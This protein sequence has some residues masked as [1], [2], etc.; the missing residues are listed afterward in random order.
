MERHWIRVAA[1]AVIV[2][3]TSAPQATAQLAP[4]RLAQQQSAVSAP[5]TAAAPQA[6]G[7][8]A[9]QPMYTPYRPQVHQQ[10]AAMTTG[11]PI[12]R[13][14]AAPTY[15][16]V[17]NNYAQVQP[18]YPTLTYPQ[19]AANY[20]TTPDYPQTTATY[21]QATPTYPETTSTYP[22]TTPYPESPQAYTPAGTQ[23]AQSPTPYRPGAMPYA[24]YATY[25]NT[26]Q[27]EELPANGEDD[28]LPPPSRNVEPMNG[29]SANGN[30]A[31]GYDANG[32]GA[33][34]YGVD[35]VNGA[36]ANGD[37]SNGAANGAA[38][39]HSMPNSNG[40]TT[41][42]EN[43]HCGHPATSYP[44]GYGDVGANCDQH[45]DWGL[46][47]YFDNPHHDSHWFGGVY[48]LLMTRDDSDHRRL[49]VMFDAPAGGYPGAEWTA[50]SSSHVDHDYR[51]GVEIRFGST[52][53]GGGHHD[54][55]DSACGT[56][57]GY[58]YG[59]DNSHHSCD[60]HEYAWEFGAW[61]LDDDVNTAQVVDSIP[62]DTDR[63]YGM[64]NFAGLSYNGRDVNEWYDYQMPVDPVN[65]TDV[66]ILAQ[67][68][69][70]SF[71]AQNVELNF[72][73]LPLCGMDSCG[74]GYAGDDCHGYGA[75]DCAPHYGSSFSMATLCG[76][77]YLRFD[78]DFEYG[79]MWATGAPGVL[80]PPAY[81]PWDGEGELV[82]D[83][84]VDNELYGFQLGANMNYS[85]SCR[86][87][88]FW[89][90]SFGMYN[91]HIEV[92]QRVFGEFGPASWTQ[93][94]ADAV[95]SAD[96]DDIAFAGEMLVGTSYNFTC[97]CRGVLAYRAVAV[98][99]VGLSVD[100]IPED[101]A[102]E[103]DVALVDSN[104]SLIIHGVQVGVEWR[105]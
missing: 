98:S 9:T 58:G 79:T 82:Y 101:F 7:P 23:Y 30:G 15:P 33:N 34:G 20:P 92:Y 5:R 29:E 102:N 55:C 14:A 57:Y 56:P 78:D 67:R 103:A 61:I 1:A 22:Q 3:G 86:C 77:R 63:I 51:S 68:V 24:P 21:P 104:G 4:Y 46:G 40:A 19:T 71:R 35:S 75:T 54:E 16:R 84:E 97:N 87:N 83:I 36:S 32:H 27:A 81:T 45:D 73:R 28:S 99:G 49:S 43:G 17:A 105:Y 42:V 74:T 13:V 50:L 88:V 100:Q 62:T 59:R 39:G 66:R 93:T 31:N 8:A 64:K 26:Q 48:Y 96:K 12:A 91:N 2:A 89:N 44:Y 72:L 95:I 76:V 6:V 85:I 47:S 60:M 41:H 25:A 69:R 90:S 70:S 53:A 37:Q 18:T 94:G 10:P 38:N 65:D 80:T 52:F 11:Q